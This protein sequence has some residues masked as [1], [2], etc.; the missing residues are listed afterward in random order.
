MK[1]IFF[2]IVGFSLV[3]FQCK[4]QATRLNPP[5]N[6]KIADVLTLKFTADQTQPHHPYVFTDQVSGFWQ[7]CLFGYNYPKTPFGS[8]GGYTL[9]S[10]RLVADFQILQGNKILSRHDASDV[11]FQPHQIDHVWHDN[12]HETLT[13]LDRQP[14]MILQLNGPIPA[15][16]QIQ[17]IFHPQTEITATQISLNKVLF[18][19]AV[20]GQFLLIATHSQL[21]WRENN[22]TLG[23]EWENYKQRGKLE[24]STAANHSIVLTLG[25]NRDELLAEAS[26]IEPEI[27]ITDKLNRVCQPLRESW[28]RSSNPEFDKAVHWAKLSGQA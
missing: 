22:K 19:D 16:Y 6:I 5:D 20:S 9:N 10:Q 27:A 11:F 21:T 17:P 13:V 2:I 3:F 23:A 1:K 24:L 18:H 7:G 4:D 12:F 8:L 14:G 15:N 26:Q 28:F 25:Y